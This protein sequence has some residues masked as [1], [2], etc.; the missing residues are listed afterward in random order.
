MRQLS[1]DR[2]RSLSVEH[3]GQSKKQRDADRGVK[4]LGRV[5]QDEQTSQGARD[6]HAAC[7]VSYTFTIIVIGPRS[8]NFRWIRKMRRGVAY[9]TSRKIVY[10]FG[11]SVED[12]LNQHLRTLW[13][14]G[15]SDV[16]AETNMILNLLKFENNLTFADGR[17]ET[18]LLEFTYYL[19]L[20]NMTSEKS[21]ACFGVSVEDDLNQTH[22]RT[23]W[24]I[25][26]SDVTRRRKQT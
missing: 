17:Y 22:L 18:K 19:Q 5:I 23:L 16:F 7:R 11:V 14:I 20:P 10:L 6:C 1:K 2:L 3:K 21:S 13:E 12:D 24:E 26:R 8:I 25:S 9:M 15:R 4:L